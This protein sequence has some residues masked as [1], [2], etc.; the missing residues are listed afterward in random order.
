MV[1]KILY[2]NFYGLVQITE[3]L[4]PFL[5]VNGKIINVSSRLGSLDR[6]ETKVKELLLDPNLT[7]EKLI[8]LAKDYEKQIKN[9]KLDGW[10]SSSYTVSKS[11]VNAYSRFALRKLVKENQMVMAVSPGWCKTDMGGPDATFSDMDGA[12]KI[13]L[14][15]DI[16]FSNQEKYNFKFFADNKIIEEN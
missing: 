10:A 1:R 16:P 12:K 14:M 13:F 8:D 5:S 11:L 6:H 9:K 15:F 7:T 4:L 3:T 2:P